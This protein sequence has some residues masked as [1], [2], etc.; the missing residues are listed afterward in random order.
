MNQELTTVTR[1]TTINKITVNPEKL[2]RLKIPPKKTLFISNISIYFNNTATKINDT[3]KYLILV[4]QLIINRLNFEEH[5][6]ALATKI[7]RL[8]ESYTNYV[9][10][11]L[12]ISTT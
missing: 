6:N 4:L 12:Y 7:S 5:I 8:L 3:A 9:V 1:R 11:Y 10:F 2:H